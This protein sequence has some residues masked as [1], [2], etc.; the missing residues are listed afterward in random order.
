MTHP[1]LT[2]VTRISD[3]AT[4]GFETRPVA[5]EHWDTGDY[6]VA[7]VNNNSGRLSTLELPDGRMTEV[8]E[9]DL[10]VGAFGTRVATLEA[11]GDWRSIDDSGELNAPHRGRPVRQ[12]HLAVTVPGSADAS[13]IP[14][15][16][17]T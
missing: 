16:C 5:R 2:S 4:H 9:D 3:L 15:S 13:A 10:L 11:V 8:M 7:R 12:S 6:V 14:G 17:A 1:F